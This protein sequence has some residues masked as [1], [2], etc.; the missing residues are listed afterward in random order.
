MGY[1]SEI[2][3]DEI[4]EI[5]SK[6]LGEQVAYHRGTVEFMDKIMPGGMGIE[7]GEMMEYI[8]NPGYYGGESAIKETNLITPKDVAISHLF[9]IRIE[10]N[11]F[12]AWCHP[13]YR[14]QRV[15][16]GK[17]LVSRRLVYLSR[18]I[19]KTRIV[20]KV[21]TIE[22]MNIRIAISRQATLLFRIVASDGF[23][24]AVAMPVTG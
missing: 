15:S 7:L 8:N 4:A 18:R 5:W 11:E 9:I 21:R 13:P 2:S 22:W 6:N 20:S 23:L 16:K 24:V 14:G 19:V 10:T 17:D 12:T 1:G 3:F